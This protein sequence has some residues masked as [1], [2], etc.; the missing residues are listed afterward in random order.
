MFKAFFVH[1]QGRLS[2]NLSAKIPQLTTLRCSIFRT[3]QTTAFVDRWG[4]LLQAAIH[5]SRS[6]LCIPAVYYVINWR[7]CTMIRTYSHP[8]AWWILFVLHL[9]SRTI[10]ECVSS[11]IFWVP[12]LAVSRWTN[13]CLH[14]CCVAAIDALYGAPVVSLDWDLLSPVWGICVAMHCWCGKGE[15]DDNQKMWEVLR[16]I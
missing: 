10:C 13:S 15:K 2:R 8:I 6:S 12:K 1:S 5:S 3:V 4:F 16:N 7:P 11:V 9:V 14:F